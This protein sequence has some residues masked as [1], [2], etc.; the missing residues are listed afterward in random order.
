MVN[1]GTANEIEGAVAN[2]VQQRAA[3]LLVGADAF[4]SSRQEQ[5]AALAL[6]HAL[7]ASADTA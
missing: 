2:A 7:P 4:L 5:I 1:A 6:R 3:A